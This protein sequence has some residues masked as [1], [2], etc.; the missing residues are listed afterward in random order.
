[1]NCHRCL[2]QLVTKYETLRLCT[3][4]WGTLCGTNI[5][6]SFPGDGCSNLSN[7]LPCESVPYDSVI[8][9]MSAAWNVWYSILLMCV[10]SR[11]YSLIPRLPHK[12]LGMGPYTESSIWQWLDKP[13]ATY[14]HW[15][16]KDVHEIVLYPTCAWVHASCYIIEPSIIIRDVLYFVYSLIPTREPGL[17]RSSTCSTYFF[18]L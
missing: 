2:Y 14:T 11:H 18:V 8:W 10:Y 13:L 16:A 7:L 17:Q 15:P 4:T 1:M 9:V 5:A 3:L 6:T 12:N